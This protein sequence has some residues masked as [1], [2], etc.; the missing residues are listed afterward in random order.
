MRCD[1]AFSIDDQ[2][3]GRFEDAEVAVLAAVLELVDGTKCILFNSV[4]SLD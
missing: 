2:P 1:E 4:L 3:L